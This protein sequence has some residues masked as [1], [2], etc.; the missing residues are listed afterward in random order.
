[1]SLSLTR[2]LIALSSLPRRFSAAP[3]VVAGIAI[4]RNQVCA[5]VLDAQGGKHEIRAI[6]TQDMAVPLF[7]EQPTMASEAG[8]VQA[9]DEISEGFRREYASVHVAL[10]DM[11]IRSTVFDL[12]DL[13][14]TAD[15][16]G[17]L[18][19]WRFAK[20]WQRSE[21]SLD[22]RGF[23]LGEDHGKRLFFG[24]AGDRPWLDCVRRALARNGIATWSLNAS[25]IYR[26][27]CFQDAVVGGA[28]ALLTLDPDCWNLQLW[29]DRG[30]VRRI[31]TR[32]RENLA[33]EYE[34]AA[35]A[36]EAERAV[37]AYVQGDGS[38]NVGRV[39]L[40]GNAAEMAALAEVFDRRLRER[41]VQ[42]HAD[43]R[44]SGSLAGMR[45]GLAPLALAAALS[46]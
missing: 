16:R 33:V 22:C 9:L 23:D 21:D 45:D 18:L 3:S 26:F 37:L 32:L 1:M 11:V 4:G 17:A 29:D 25:S 30:R 42:L 39:Y 5:V 8:L 15:M 19:R 36:D 40:A 6:H 2:P 14:K 20:E 13:P 24:Q 34:M 28:G 7:A 43:E 44:I 41:A 10:P 46:T 12:D 35:I 27:N 38:R 31:L